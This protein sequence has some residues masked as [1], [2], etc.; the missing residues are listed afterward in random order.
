MATKKNTSKAKTKTTS[1]VK[2]VPTSKVT[3][4]SRQTLSLPRLQW[5]SV[6]LLLLAVVATVL[7]MNP[8]SYSLTVSHLT[9]DK[10]QGGALA[11]AY[12]HIVDLEIRW[13][14][15]VILSV[16]AIGQLLHATRLKQTFA[17]SLKTQQMPWRW[18][19][20]AIVNGLMAETVALLCGYQDLATLK[21]F[22]LMAVITAVF[23]WCAERQAAADKSEANLSHLAAVL[24][25]AVS[26]VLIGFSLLF[27]SVY[28]Q[29]RASWYVYGA[30]AVFV[31]NLGMLSLNQYNQ[32]R[33]YK[34]WKN[35]EIV[36]RNYTI[37]TLVSLLAFAAVLILGLSK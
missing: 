26:V 33:A 16:A 2:A 13:I 22:G 19:G 5:A 17:N 27:T 25:A 4:T 32:L 21:L 11:P 10:L 20:L 35:Y 28:G 8:A 23:S 30:F 7:F 29:V 36:E 15:I 14:L 24:T 9:L 1:R 6:V 12:R 3:I 34:N 18:V 37:I 31:V